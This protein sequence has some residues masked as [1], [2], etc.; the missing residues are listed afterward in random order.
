MKIKNLSLSFGIHEIFKNIDLNI[1]ENEKIGIVGVNGAGKPTFFKLIM[2]RL[3]PD[4]G[5]IILE[6]DYNV[7]LIPQVLEDEQKDLSIDVFS[8][9]ESGRP[10][11]E[12]ETYLQNIYEEIANEDTELKQKNLFKIIGVIKQSF[13][14]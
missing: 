13:N 10:I 3:E 12:L 11:R 9:L 2:K 7:D 1:P 14:K 6:E 8:Y 5:K 4:E